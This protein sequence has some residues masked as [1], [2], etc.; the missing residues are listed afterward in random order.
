MLEEA[1]RT[2]EIFALVIAAGGAAIVGYAVLFKR[3]IFVMAFGAV[4]GA[5]ALVAP[6]L[7]RGQPIS[8]IVVRQDEASVEIERR[9]GFYGGTYTA[10]SGTIIPIEL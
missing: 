2:A 7:L 8:V 5:A 4:L 3:N 1:S 9:D 6:V 10:R